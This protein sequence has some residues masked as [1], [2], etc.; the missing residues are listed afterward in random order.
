MKEGYLSF[1]IVANIRLNGKLQ[2]DDLI[3]TLA[4]LV[5]QINPLTYVDLNNAQ[6]TIVAE[7]LKTTLCLGIVK[8]FT[9]FKKYNLLEAGTTKTPVQDS[10]SKSNAESAVAT[11]ETEPVAAKMEVEGQEHL[12]E[13]N[14][15][16]SAVTAME[17]TSVK[18]EKQ[19]NPPAV[20]AELI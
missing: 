15:T 6:Y 4:E 14:E 17:E 12:S 8:D 19:E 1:R 3:K 18:V 20:A 5:P 2:R 11:A 10:S 16:G 13:G 9:K 7:V